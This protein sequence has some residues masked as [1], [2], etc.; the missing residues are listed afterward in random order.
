MSAQN[1]FNVYSDGYTARFF[2]AAEF[3]RMLTRS[4]FTVKDIRIVGQKSELLPF[5]GVGAL[6]RLKYAILPAIPNSAAESILSIV[7]GFLFVTAEKPA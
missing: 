3:A 2:S 7:G 1:V 6:G 4:E 5:P